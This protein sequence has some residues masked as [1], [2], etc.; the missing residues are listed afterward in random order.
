MTPNTP[1]GPTSWCAV[2]IW[3]NFLVFLWVLL[4]C[5][6]GIGMKMFALSY[7]IGF[8][9]AFLNPA[10]TTVFNGTGAGLSTLIA[11]LV[12]CLAAPLMNLVPY[13]MSSAFTCMKGNAV[14]ASKD[15][16]RLF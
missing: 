7:D 13:V 9:L 16:S 3:G 2:W 5:K 8:C 6:C 11:T 14:Q 10:N 15:T 1:G 12:A 4:W